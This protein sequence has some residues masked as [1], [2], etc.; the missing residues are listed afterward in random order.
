MLAEVQGLLAAGVSASACD[1]SGD[2]AVCVAALGGNAR[3]VSALLMNGARPTQVRDFLSYCEV[4]MALCLCGELHWGANHGNPVDCH[5]ERCMSLDDST[6]HSPNRSL[7]PPRGPCFWQREKCTTFKET[8]LHLAARHNF[9]AVVDTLLTCL[10]SKTFV[11]STD[12]LVARNYMG[13]TAL[14]VAAEKG[15]AEVCTQLV[16][17]GASQE[18]LDHSGRTPLQLAVYWVSL[19][20]AI[21]SLI[22]VRDEVL[23]CIFGGCLYP[24]IP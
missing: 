18:G 23:V 6:R 14:H 4:R 7:T 17:A 20:D 10:E 15:H 21:L 9:T 5:I 22:G 16:K 24:N 2:P 11:D 8:P 13:A 12:L 19:D 3:V 1:A